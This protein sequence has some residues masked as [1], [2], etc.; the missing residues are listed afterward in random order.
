MYFE[1]FP[2]LSEKLF[3]HR[4]SRLFSE[5]RRDM[6]RGTKRSLNIIPVKAVAGFTARRLR[7]DSR[8]VHMRFLVEKVTLGEVSLRVFILFFIS[9]IPLMFRTH[10]YLRI[11]LTRRKNWR[12]L[13][14]FQKA[15]LFR[16]YENIG[17]KS[18]F[19]PIFF[20]KRTVRTATSTFI[21]SNQPS[22][23]R[24]CANYF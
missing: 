23:T 5:W 15:M 9:I 11:F 2:Q 12:S 18:R 3:Q 21:C 10:L 13:G 20:F 14:I 1:L 7:F 16:K 19:T 22:C 17:Y 6:L 8:S 24:V 4:F